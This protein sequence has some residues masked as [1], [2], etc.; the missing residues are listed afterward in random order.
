MARV[1]RTLLIFGGFVAVL[2]AAFYPI[3][4]RPL[5]HLEEYSKSSGD[6]LTLLPF[7]FNQWKTLLFQWKHTLGVVEDRTFHT[8]ICDFFLG[9]VFGYP[10][11][12][13][14]GGRQVRWSPKQP[15]RLFLP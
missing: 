13:L 9:G 15:I 1:P 10:G 6:S 2:G 8:W 14:L 5:M 4:F 12:W 3:Y 7:C 11:N